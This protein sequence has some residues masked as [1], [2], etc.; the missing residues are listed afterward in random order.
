MARSIK[1]YWEINN[2]AIDEAIRKFEILQ[3]KAEAAAIAIAKATGGGRTGIVDN[4]GVEAL[5][6]QEKIQKAKEKQAKTEK[7]AQQ[8]LF[9]AAETERKK[10]KAHIE[11]VIEMR[12]SATE[13][14]QSSSGGG[15]G[16]GGGGNFSIP[17]LGGGLLGDD[18]ILGGA[19][20]LA[21]AL[22]GA[23]AA[24]SA[25][26]ET[27]KTVYSSIIGAAAE[28][29]N[30]QV[31][32]A[33]AF[34][35]A[36]VAGKGFEENLKLAESAMIRIQELAAKTPFDVNQL[37]DSYIKLT[38]RGMRPTEE[39]LL[40]I[41][42]L[43]SFSSKSI[44]QLTEA[45]L[46]AQ[47]GNKRRLEEFGIDMKVEAGKVKLA[48][49]EISV[50][51][52]KIIETFSKLGEMPGI[53]EA[54]V[55]Q[56]ETL[57]GMFNTMKDTFEQF[58]SAIG[59]SPAMFDTLKTAAGPIMALFEGLKLSAFA[60]GEA[61]GEPLKALAEAIFPQTTQAAEP[62]QDMIKRIALVF[63]NIA[64]I[65][66]DILVPIFK[67][68]G[69]AF[70]SIKERIL[71]NNQVFGSF[72]AIIKTV[73]IVL[74]QI[75][76][77]IM[78][79]IDAAA[80]LFAGI[81]EMQMGLLGGMDVFTDFLAVL[82]TI[83]DICK[84][85]IN[86]FALWARI[87]GED[88]VGGLG[89]I[90][91]GDFQEGMTRI[92]R[93]LSQSTKALVD[94]VV[95]SFEG[96]EN[97]YEKIRKEIKA[98][99]TELPPPKKG[100]MPGGADLAPVTSD[101]AS[102][103]KKASDEKKKEL[104][105]ELGLL[106]KLEYEKRRHV[107]AVIAI[108]NEAIKNRER[109]ETKTRKLAEETLI[110]EEELFKEKEKYIKEELAIKRK[111]LEQ[112]V[113][114]GEKT[115]KDLEFFDKKAKKEKEEREFEHQTKMIELMHK[116]NEAKR[117]EIIALA[118]FELKMDE[119]KWAN[120]LENYKM[121]LEREKALMQDRAK[122]NYEHTSATNLRTLQIDKHLA[123]TEYEAQKK[124][125]MARL[126]LHERVNNLTIEQEQEIKL[127]LEKL[128]AAHAHRINQIIDQAA[129]EQLEIQRDIAETRK[130]VV[131]S[132]LK[133]TED[134]LNKGLGDAAGRSVMN[135]LTL[136]KNLT[137]LRETAQKEI[138]Q[139][140]SIGT[141]EALDLAA[142]LEKKLAKDSMKLI[143]NQIG[144]AVSG[145]ISTINDTINKIQQLRIAKIDEQIN[146]NNEEI[147]QLKE[148]AELEK[149]RNEE[150]LRRQEIDNKL[151]QQR[152]DELT[153]LQTSVPESE[154]AMVQEQ[155]EL[156]KHRIKDIEKMKTEAANKENE[157]IRKLEEENKRL[158]AE[159]RKVQREQFEINRAAQIAQT[160]I[161]GTV[162]AINAFA[163]LAA[164][165]IVGPGLGAAM[166]ATIGAFTAAQVA[167]I[168]AQPNPY[169][170]GT[171]FVQGNKKDTDSVP[172][173]LQPGEAVI[174]VRE[175]KDYHETIK[176]I[177][178]REISHKELNTI[179]KKI[180]NRKWDIEGYSG[181]SSVIINQ[182]DY[183]PIVEAINNK[184]VASF[185]ID[186]DG[187]EVYINTVSTK[188][189]ILNRKLRIK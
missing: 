33:L 110:H 29:E 34:Q 176:A 183:K 174:P 159:K 155:I 17:N 133:D 112:E 145:I 175:N 101:N 173:I 182:L 106:Q 105:R 10:E 156:Q 151:A 140:K 188:T 116:A 55:K 135:I 115:L 100:E 186:H 79:L 71:G 149:Q 122:K 88:V 83:L 81:W 143:A 187:L 60:F 46:D 178:N 35:G 75:W 107:Q 4:V 47:Q 128:E 102:K 48:I 76:D 74:R 44:D 120:Q 154:R 166:A 132:I 80:G 181:G 141:Q 45:I 144:E 28:T 152:I 164:I 57:T 51:G 85:L 37:T 119:K 50:E 150:L 162:A 89:A 184:P 59:T 87:I 139:L 68:L 69:S 92:V 15:R 123:D 146:K 32:L 126:E 129:R 56:S 95:K 19:S 117:A 142:I 177:F 97:R 99:R 20:M 72:K 23:V 26:A 12:K 70:T 118:E 189:K 170:E 179:V 111:I 61:L 9:N 104:E 136:K 62:M 18:G 172:A 161:S 93:G 160:I 41:G 22:N 98:E 40:A 42:N 148:I 94:G 2:D 163:S 168:A 86:A 39:Q 63:A 64:D 103:N 127:E 138:K 27:L 91:R 21:G 3:K 158:E 53:N 25:L 185:N 157:R 5:A 16:G 30:L 67:M 113:A 73:I 84:D 78:N 124:R 52:E 130:K 109:N 66:K 108:E 38:K 167:L 171:L 125:L 77:V 137:D 7:D 180:K 147:E 31:N 82:T 1:L 13:S 43:A 169:K 153:H 121:S 36:N 54:M 90:L 96:I 11:K 24:G 134:A 165:P 6:N 8:S 58:L 14:G 114:A 49:G 65:I 131:E